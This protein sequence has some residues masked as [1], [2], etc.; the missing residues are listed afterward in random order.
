MGSSQ[1]M[2]MGL[3]KNSILFPSTEAPL[4]YDIRDWALDYSSHGEGFS[5][6]SVA[7]GRLMNYLQVCY[8]NGFDMGTA[9]ME[10]IQAKA[11]QVELYLIQN[12]IEYID[13]R[14]N[15]GALWVVGGHE[16]DSVMLKASEVGYKFQFSDKGGK[17]TKH[18][19]GWYYKN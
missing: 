9:E 17:V 19:P 12:Q 14:K 15:G 3:E 13:K 5:M 8:Q 1:K 16:L 10:S 7:A 11:D 2:T 6:D 4:C 18:Q